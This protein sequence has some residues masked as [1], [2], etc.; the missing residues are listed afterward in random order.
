[1]ELFKFINLIDE[2]LKPE[3]VKIH[4]A[5]WNGEDNPLDVYLAGDFEYWQSFQTKKNFEREY[6]VR[7]FN[8][9]VRHSPMPPD[10]TL[11]IP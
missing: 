11:R 5:G 8:F 9:E 7:E 4:L 3:T 2:R 6:I 1:M 10:G